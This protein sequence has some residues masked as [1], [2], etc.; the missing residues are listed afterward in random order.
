M[1]SRVL[2]GLRQFITAFITFFLVV[3]FIV[4]CSFLLFLQDFEPPMELLVPAAKITFANILLFTLI[5]VIIDGFRRKLTIERPVREISEALGK[6]M[7]GDFSVRLRPAGYYTGFA[8]IMRSINRMTEELSGL[9]TLRTDFVSSVSHE[10][11]TPLAVMQNFCTLLQSPDLTDAEREEYAEAIAYECRRLSDLMTNILKLNRLENQQLFPRAESFDLAEQ[12]RECLLQ[13][14]P[15]W[16]EKALNIEADLPDSLML[17]ADSELLWLVWNNLL[18]NA[19]KFTDRGTVSLSL[20]TTD[21][22][23]VVTVSDTGCG[24]SPEVGKR[25]FEKFYQGDTSHA[26]EGNG[27]GLALVKRIINIVGGEISVSSTAGTGSSFIV[28]LHR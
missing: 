23:A 11:K 16:E 27:L 10:M 28:R 19:F 6:I 3:A 8:E 21:A 14:E 25:I 24:M 17:K 7:E 4:T 13:F 15:L 9:E 12:L 26:T 5:F 2:E 22:H 18:S 20:H 1:K